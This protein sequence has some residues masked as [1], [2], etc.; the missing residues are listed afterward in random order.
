MN[1]NKVILG[2][3]CTRDP[4]VKFLP[5]GDAVADVGIAVNVYKRGA[6]GESEQEGHFFDATAFGK[7]AELLGEHYAKGSPILVEGRL[8]QDR[9][10][11]DDGNNR[12]RVKVR[13]SNLVF[14]PRAGADSEGDSDGSSDSNEPT[15]GF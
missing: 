1:F 2:G 7:T 13:I 3:R 5:S 11:D 8:H 10:Q 6:D 9:W 15:V 4:E 14:L 12:S